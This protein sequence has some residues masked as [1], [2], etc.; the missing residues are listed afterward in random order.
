MAHGSRVA[1]VGCLYIGSQNLAQSRKFH[2]YL[3]CNHACLGTLVL[4]FSLG[5]R[6]AVVGEAETGENLL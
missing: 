3:G 5:F 4:Q 2:D 1:L 6:F